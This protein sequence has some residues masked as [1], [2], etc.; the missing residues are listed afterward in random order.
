M[1][2]TCLPDIQ[3]ARARGWAVAVLNPNTSSWTDPKSGTKQFV[4]GMGGSRHGLSCWD[5]ILSKSPA[6]SIAMIAHSAGGGVAYEMLRKRPEVL[7]RTQFLALTDA[8]Q[9]ISRRDAPDLQRF[10]KQ[11]CLDWVTS[12]PRAQIKKQKG[13]LKAWVRRHGTSCEL[14]CRRGHNA[15]IAGSAAPCGRESSAL[16]RDN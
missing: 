7:K 15:C 4:R 16:A 11:Q 14:S 9:C 2:G 12:P 5:A 3:H 8:V 6:R 1:E 10:Y 13:G